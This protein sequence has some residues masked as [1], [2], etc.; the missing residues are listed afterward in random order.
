MYEVDK[1]SP[2]HFSLHDSVSVDLF[3]N[4]DLK[5]SLTIAFLD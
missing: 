2:K 5:N 4:E 1:I 3:K